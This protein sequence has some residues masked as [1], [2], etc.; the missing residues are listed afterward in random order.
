MTNPN[1]GRYEERRESIGSIRIRWRLLHSILFTVQALP[2]MAF[3][4]WAEL[5]QTT[6]DSTVDTAKAIIWGVALV[7]GASIAVTA[8]FSE[9]L[10]LMLGTR[11]LINDWLQRR[12]DTAEAKGREEMRAEVLAWVERRDAALE[13]SEPFD[14]PPPGSDKS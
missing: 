1:G 11:D 4:T 5:T 9:V 13:K 10:E 8:T 12:R 7:G 6:N 3:I 14:E 2:G